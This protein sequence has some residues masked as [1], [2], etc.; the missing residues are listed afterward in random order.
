MQPF[1][2]RFYH[3]PSELSRDLREIWRERGRVRAL[4]KGKLIDAAFRERLMLAVTE[5]NRCR[6]CQYAHARMA[7]IAG[8]AQSDV[9]S[10]VAGNLQGSPPEQVPAL[11]YA[12]HWAETEADPDLAARRRVLEVYGSEQLGSIELSLRMIRV[13]NLIGNTWDYLLYRA[14]FGRLGNPEPRAG[15]VEPGGN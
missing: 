5:V 15:I 14:S 13:G 9:D 8:L 6:Y 10:L 12:Q 2:R 4:M 3:K 11:L 7:L 1:R